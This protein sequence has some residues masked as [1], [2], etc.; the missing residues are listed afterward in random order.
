MDSQKNFCS[1]LP[2]SSFFII[3]LSGSP[4]ISNEIEKNPTYTLVKRVRSSYSEVFSFKKGANNIFANQFGISGLHICLC[5]QFFSLHYKNKSSCTLQLFRRMLHL[6]FNVKKQ[7]FKAPFFDYRTAAET[8]T[9][10]IS[11]S[12]FVLTNPLSCPCIYNIFFLK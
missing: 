10:R 4:E 7:K 5:F 6:S 9:V 1:I 2:Y 12:F 8:H 3:Q 11:F